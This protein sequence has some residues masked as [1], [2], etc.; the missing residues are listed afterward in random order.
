MPHTNTHYL[1]EW[2][3][4]E[5]AIAEE[6]DLPMTEG[7]RVSPEDLN[8]EQLTDEDIAQVQRDPALQRFY[9]QNLMQEGKYFSD[10]DMLAQSP[11]GGAAKSYED[12]TKYDFISG[13]LDEYLKENSWEDF[14]KLDEKEIQEKIFGLSGEEAPGTVQEDPRWGELRAIFG[15]RGGQQGTPTGLGSLTDTGIFR[16]FEDLQSGFGRLTSEDVSVDALTEQLAETERGII[17]P[18]GQLSG[19][20]GLESDITGLGKERGILGET[21]QRKLA[22]TRGEYAPMEKISRYGTLAGTG[23]GADP[24]QDY[25]SSIY[26][27]IG[28]YETGIRDIGKQMGTPGGATGLYGDIG[29]EYEDIYS[30]LYGTGQ[31]SIKDIYSVYG[32]IFRGATGGPG[33]KMWWEV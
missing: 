33:G 26:G 15:G 17:G 23:V 6:F 8:W 13:E 7:R 9:L 27:D 30:T 14:L 2:W 31:G 5:E 20:T 28:T 32:D 21:L 16:Y 18:Y 25:L 29:S 24:T 19:I 10:A 4:G 11:G 1:P 3:Q 12:M 22:G